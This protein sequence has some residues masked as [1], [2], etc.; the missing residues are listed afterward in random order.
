MCVLVVLE[1]GGEQG[2]KTVD[3][4]EAECGMELVVEYGHAVKPA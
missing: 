3:D 2:P 4:C 1:T